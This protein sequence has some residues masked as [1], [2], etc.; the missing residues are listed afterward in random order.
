MQAASKTMQLCCDDD[1]L[2]KINRQEIHSKLKKK[3]QNP[4]SHLWIYTEQ[5]DI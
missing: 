4:L 3:K 1:L 2:G 5:T